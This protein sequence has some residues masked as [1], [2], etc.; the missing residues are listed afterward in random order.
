MMSPRFTP[1]DEQLSLVGLGDGGFLVIAPPGSGKTT[2]LT[3]RVARLISNSSETFRILALTFTNKAAENMRRRLFESV[4]EH[5]SRVTACTIHS[6]CLEALRN[7]GESVGV[8]ENASI[9]ENEHDRIAAL[10]R[11]LVDEGIYGAPSDADDKQL[12][13]ILKSIS[14]LKRSLIPPEE[15]PLTIEEGIAPLGVAYAAY[16][17]TLRLF[18]ALDFDDILFFA[19]RLFL[20]AERVATQY[21]RVYRYVVIDEAQ[22]TNVAQYEVIRAL[23]GT[24][25][26]NVMLVADADQSIFRFAGATTNNLLR[27]E[28]DFN[29]KRLGLTQNFRCAG[30]IVEAANALIANNASRITTG[31]KMTSAVLAT[32]FV[33]AKSYPTEEDEAAATLAII[34]LLEQQEL[35]ASWCYP[36][37]TTRLASEDICVLGRSRYALAPVLT[38][39]ESEGRAFQFSAGRDGL[40][41]SEAFV[42]FESALRLVNN[43]ADVLAR[44]SLA[45]QE[46]PGLDLIADTAPLASLIERLAGWRRTAFQPLLALQS[47]AASLESTI[48]E[49]IRRTQAATFS[50]EDERA[51]VLADAISLQ[52][53]WITFRAHYGSDATVARL[54]GEIALAGRGGVDGPGV[55]VLTIHAAKGLEF[56]AVILVGMNEG[57]FPDYRSKKPD[58]LADE[59]RNAYVGITRAERALFLLRPRSR[60]MPWGDTKPQ[61]ASR[62]IAEANLQMVDHD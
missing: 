55:R 7:Y 40:F 48:D 57:T 42:G 21:R 58:D 39:M 43:P 33:E 26:R 23:C 28:R 17:R 36:G 54:L 13:N 59:R 18:G 32:G 56:R 44:R 35:D 45:R 1:T 47:A 41:E 24:A 15:A 5:S 2:V 62:F 4:G 38:A 61:R 60:V 16:D 8:P 11:G 49:V 31:N 3:E 50:D 29:A 53:R 46:R 6:F 22:D 9:Y 51:V 14:A 10:L 12:G 25:L 19:Y 37:E 27:F 20:N 34:D 30:K 52:K